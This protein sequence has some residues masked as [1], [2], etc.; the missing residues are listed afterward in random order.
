MELARYHMH[1][2]P[3]QKTPLSQAPGKGVRKLRLVDQLPR[4]EVLINQPCYEFR[5]LCAEK[6]VLD[7]GC[8]Y[9]RNRPIV[10][11][12]GGNWV[13]VEPFEGGSCTVVGR[14]ENLPFSDSSFDIVIMDAVL[15]HVEDVGASFTEVARVLRPGGAFIGYVAFMECFHEISYS[16]LSY[17][18]LEYYAKKNGLALERLAGGHRF[19]IDYHLQVL[20]YPLP[21]GYLRPIVAASMRAIFRIK[22]AA[23]YLAMRISRGMT[24]LAAAEMARNYYLVECLRQSVGFSFVIRNPVITDGSTM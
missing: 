15:E 2:G 4:C 22:S 16:H 6:N 3:R 18:A 17:M 14:A 13:G 12:V 8:G 9:G 5:T 1:Q 11:A 21:F 19:G 23:A 24:H 10:E 20:C 7:V